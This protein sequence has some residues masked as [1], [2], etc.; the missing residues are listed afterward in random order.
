MNKNWFGVALPFITGM[1]LSA[2]AADI[3]WLGKTTNWKD[4][5]NWTSSDGSWSDGLSTIFKIVH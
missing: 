5:G 4:S 2:G 3:Y 1:A